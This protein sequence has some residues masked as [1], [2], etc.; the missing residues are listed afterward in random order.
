MDG[1]K[2]SKFAQKDEEDG[3][4]EEEINDMIQE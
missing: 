3:D 1:N 4:E 2:K